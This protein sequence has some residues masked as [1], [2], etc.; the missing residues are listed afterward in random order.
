M[1]GKCGYDLPFDDDGKRPYD[2]VAG[3]VSEIQV[4]AILHSKART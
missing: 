2:L 3:Q 1:T 4:V